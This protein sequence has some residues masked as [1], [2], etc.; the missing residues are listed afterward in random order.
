MLS[1]VLKDHISGTGDRLKIF[2]D[3]KDNRDQAMQQRNNH[4]MLPLIVAKEQ[5]NTASMLITGQANLTVLQWRFLPFFHRQTW[6]VQCCS[7]KTAR[8][9]QY[10]I[11]ARVLMSLSFPLYGNKIEM[12]VTKIRKWIY[13]EKNA[14]NVDS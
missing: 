2:H 4:T 3:S 13:L 1:G 10:M 7:E 12:S 11:S 5:M 14:Q 8:I 9:R 6:I